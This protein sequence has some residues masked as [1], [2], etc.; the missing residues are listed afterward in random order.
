MQDMIKQLIPGPLQKSL[1]T[2]GETHLQQESQTRGNKGH[3][4]D[5]ECDHPEML[6]QVRDPSERLCD[7]LQKRRQT[8]LPLSQHEINGITDDPGVEQIEK[9]DQ[10]GKEDP[11][12]KEF[13]TTLQEI[14]QGTDSLTFHIK[15]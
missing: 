12:Y 15:P 13:F 4:G 14:Q 2:A 6:P 7:R 5:D 9:R 8:A 11:Q 1:H 3:T 10:H